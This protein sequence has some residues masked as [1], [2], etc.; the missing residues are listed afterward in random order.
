MT[1]AT[2]PRQRAISPKLIGAAD[3]AIRT[4]PG[5]TSG[6]G[7]S[8]TSMTSVGRPCRTTRTAL[9]EPP[10]YNEQWSLYH[11]QRFCYNSLMAT[12]ARE[13]A[14]PRRGRPPSG[15]SL[16]RDDVV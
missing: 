14:A 12:R 15:E 13:R 16:D 5:S 9:I 8:W 3:T 1:L 7:M 6:T 11:G 4:T 10:R 2:P